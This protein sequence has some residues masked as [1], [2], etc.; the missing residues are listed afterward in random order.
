MRAASAP[1]W[2]LVCDEKAAASA[3]WAF[4]VR[5]M[6]SSDSTVRRERMP[7]ALHD[8]RVVGADVQRG[9]ERIVD[10]VFRVEVTE[11]V[12]VEVARE[13]VVLMQR[14]PPRPPGSGRR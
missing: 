6:Y 14:V 7:D 1:V 3:G 9:Q 5:A 10:H 2:A 8:P 12:D 4:F 11:P 13:A